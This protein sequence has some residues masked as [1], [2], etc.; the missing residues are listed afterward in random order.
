MTDIESIVRRH[1]CEVAGRPASDAARLPLDDDLT[2]DF[3]LA[4]LELIV[5]LSGVCDTARVP[6]T[7]FGEDDLAKL[8]TGRDIVNLL[9]AKVHA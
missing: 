7:E 2:F 5:L 3:G 9:A 6:L 4:S 1:L 8:R